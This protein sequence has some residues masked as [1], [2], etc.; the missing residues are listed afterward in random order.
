MAGTVARIS[1]RAGLFAIMKRRMAEQADVTLATATIHNPA[2]IRH[3][4]RLKP[5]GR[6]VRILRDGAVLAESTGAV[7]LLEVGR[8]VYDPVIYVPRADVRASLGPNDTSTHCPLKGDAAYFDLLDETGTV[9]Q[10]KI[11]WTYPQPF[12]F[13]TEL[14][15]L[16]AFYAD[17]VTIEESP[18]QN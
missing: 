17:Q 2:E 18:I 8:D 14:N 1:G 13:A 6:R 16:V 3:F 12:D 15:G 7:R 9:A 11:A 4:M 10:P 5:V